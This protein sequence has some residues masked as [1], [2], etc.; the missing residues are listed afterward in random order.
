MREQFGLNG[1][2]HNSPLLNLPR[3]E[4]SAL[5]TRNDFC[6]HTE[7]ESPSYERNGSHFSVSRANNRARNLEEVTVRLKWFLISCFR[8][9]DSVSE[10]YE[11]I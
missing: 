10:R 6:K 1:S 5:I 8:M 7:N 11:S 4:N 9:S 3:D 2:N